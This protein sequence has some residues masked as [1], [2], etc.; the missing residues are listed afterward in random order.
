[1]NIPQQ[2]QLAG[3]T[4]DVNLDDTYIKE[5]SRIGEANYFAQQITID[6]TTPKKEMSEQAFYHELVHWILYIMNED[7]LRQNEK[8]VDIFGHLLYQYT[9]TGGLCIKE[10]SRAVG[11]DMKT[12]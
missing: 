9:K 3:I 10:S 8:F 4:I 6:P 7:E 11:L 5:N 2:F 1:M 12:E